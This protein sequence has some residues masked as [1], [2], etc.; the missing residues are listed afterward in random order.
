[1]KNQASPLSR[2]SFNVWMRPPK[3]ETPARTIGIGRYVAYYISDGHDESLMRQAVEM[4]NDRANLVFEVADDAPILCMCDGEQ[5]AVAAREV[6]ADLLLH[7]I[8]QG[9][10]T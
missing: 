10:G 6:K 4:C 2:Y 8:E 9:G 7:V 3:K 1:M 5:R